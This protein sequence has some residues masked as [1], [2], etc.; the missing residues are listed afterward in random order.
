[1]DSSIF[2][3]H[4]RKL[5]YEL[6]L[7]LNIPIFWCSTHRWAHLVLRW[8]NGTCCRTPDTRQYLQRRWAYTLY[9]LLQYMKHHMKLKRHWCRIRNQN[10]PVLTVMMQQS[11]MFSFLAHVIELNGFI[12]ASGGDEL[13]TGWNCSQWCCVCMM[14]KV[15]LNCPLLKDT[16]IFF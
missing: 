10:K 16:K 11:P 15:G 6:W 5:T 9:A 4:F 3:V 1:M 13:I 14:G 2:C 12:F 7:I 8:I